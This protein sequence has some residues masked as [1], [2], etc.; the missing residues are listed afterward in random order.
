VLE[1][2]PYGS[3]VVISA[4][5]ETACGATHAVTLAGGEGEAMADGVGEAFGVGG[6]G[7]EAGDA[8]DD[9]FGEARRRWW[10]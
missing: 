5:D 3:G 9:L 7:G 2:A 8:V 1:E 6:G 4:G 10:R